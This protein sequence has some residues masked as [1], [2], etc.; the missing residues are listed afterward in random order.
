MILS[1]EKQVKMGYN[2]RYDGKFMTVFTWLTMSK[3]AIGL[4]V[5]G[6]KN[7]SQLDIQLQGSELVCVRISSLRL[8]NIPLWEYITFCFYFHLSVNIWVGYC[9]YC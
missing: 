2:S 4:G 3:S 6:K 7:S 8:N 1:F 9:Q 5:Q